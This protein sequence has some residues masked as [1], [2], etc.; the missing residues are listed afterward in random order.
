MRRAFCVIGLSILASSTAHA[1]AIGRDYGRSM[2]ISQRGIAAT[3]Q[4]LASQAG[5][6]I[7]A[8]GGSAVDAAIAANAVLGVT[9]PM[10]T[11]LGGDL[12]VIY[13]DAKT[14]KLTGLNASGP[15]PK[16]L[17]PEFLA[18]RGI[19][20]MP[21]T[22]IHSVTVPG[23]VEGWYKIHQR[24]GKLPWKDLFDDAITFAEQGFPVHEGAQEI[25]AGA[26]VVRGLKA[27]PESARVFLPGGK[28]PEVGQIFR[29]PDMG[30]AFRL[31]AEQ[32]PSAFYKGAIAAAILKTSQ[33]LGGTMTAQDL[34]SFSA[35]WVQPL[36]IDYRGWKVYE[37]P[38]NGQGMAALEMLEY[39]GE[40]SAIGFRSAQRRRNSQ[41][42]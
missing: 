29:N 38:P 17:T 16:A 33:H 3:S 18:K 2:V 35:E 26:G 20:R 10:M 4:V 9:E 24:F 14:G 37:L 21:Y 31:I 6:Q 30:K 13:W 39:Y 8:R 22:G 11:G 28:A 27:N 7:L 32:G 23:A 36:S 25:W 1:Q 15:A 41:T 42:N 5:A 40:H 19:D 34:A 12:F